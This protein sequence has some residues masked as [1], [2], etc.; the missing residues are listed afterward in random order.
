M[1]L[2]NSTQRNSLNS[3]FFIIWP[4]YNKEL[5][6]KAVCPTGMFPGATIGSPGGGG[7]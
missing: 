2:L 1:D 4:Q 7:P 5:G 3:K 6:S